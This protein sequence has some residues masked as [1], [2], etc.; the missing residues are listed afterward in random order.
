[1]V[2]ELASSTPPPPCGWSPSPSRRDGEEHVIANGRLRRVGAGRWSKV[3]EQRFLAELATH[4]GIRRAC[5]AIWLSTQAVD[6]RRGKD[7]HLDAACEAAAEIGRKR[8]NAWLIEAGNR[9]F[10]PDD[11]PEGA[12]F[13]LPKVTVAEAIAIAR[14]GAGRGIAPAASAAPVYE[15]YKPAEVMKRLETKMR[16][17]GLLRDEGG[18][19]PERS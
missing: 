3:K 10:D 19:A 18:G 8:L 9:T 12:D 11:L 16:L 17:L 4:G 15:P 1:M 14:L 5:K 7:R 6:R 13:E 2:N